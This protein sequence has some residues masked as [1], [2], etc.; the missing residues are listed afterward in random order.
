[1]PRV[2]TAFGQ[3]YSGFLYETMLSPIVRGATFSSAAEPAL[4]DSATVAG[5]APTATVNFDVANQSVIYLTTSAGANWTVNFRGSGGTPL[6]SFMNVGQSVTV[7]MLTTQGATAYYNSAVQIDGASVTPKWQGGTAPTAGNSSSVDIYVY[8]I[9]KTGN[10]AFTVF[11]A[12][13]KFA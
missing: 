9:V 11:A 8:T 3:Q 4:I 13:T 12:Q 6:N 10:A 1:M 7:A 2:S 5:S